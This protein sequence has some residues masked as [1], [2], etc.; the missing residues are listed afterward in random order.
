MTLLPTQHRLVVSSE[1]PFRIVHANA[2]YFR[3]A[4]LKSSSIIGQFLSTV[5]EEPSEGQD[6]RS[7]LGPS[8]NPS[9]QQNIAIHKSD[10]VVDADRDQNKKPPGAEK[11]G[12]TEKTTSSTVLNCHMSISPVSDSSSTRDMTSS[13]S[14]RVKITHYLLEFSEAD[15]AVAGD[16]DKNAANALDEGF[17]VIG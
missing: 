13:V 10:L 15:G 8:A 1:D 5:L 9:E 7:M 4:G 12:E 16:I 17:S 3:L 14:G 2:A 11:S 6:L